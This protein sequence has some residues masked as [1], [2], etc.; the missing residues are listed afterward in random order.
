MMRC[1]DRT[2][3]TGYVKDEYESLCRALGV[4]PFVIAPGF[5]A[6]VNPLSMGP[7]GDGWEKLSA[8]EA[9]RRATIIF[10]RWLVLVR[11]LVGSMKIDDERR[12]PFGPDESDGLRNAL[13]ILP[14]Y[15]AGHSVLAGA[16][17]ARKRLA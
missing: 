15:A 5:W 17:M 7:L 14:G 12:V 2:R 1:G 9:Q 10:K 4:E 3:V 6:R 13:A 11:G 16:T 8:E